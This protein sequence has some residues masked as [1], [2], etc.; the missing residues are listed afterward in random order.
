MA[1][2]HS[3]D[4]VLE[5]INPPTT[6]DEQQVYD[7][8]NKVMLPMFS[9]KLLTSKGKVL[10]Q[11]QQAT[12]DSH[13]LWQQLKKACQGHVETNIVGGNIWTKL[14]TFHIGDS[15]R[16]GYCSIFFDK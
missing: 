7:L 13:V 10:L 6:P 8:Q 9:E 15:W 3:C 16:K 5:L 2:S 11:A 1:A 4:N 14:V 12:K